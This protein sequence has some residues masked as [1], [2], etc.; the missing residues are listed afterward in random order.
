MP[1]TMRSYRDTRD[2]LAIVA[3]VQTQ[4]LKSRHVIDFPWRLSSPALYTGKDAQLWEDENGVLLG[5]AAWQLSWAALDFFIRPGS[6]SQETENAIF[7]W[8]AQ[9]FCQ[10]DQERGRPLP[11]WVEHRDDDTQRKAISER[12][13]FLLDDDYSYVHMQCSLTEPLPEPVLPPGF[14]IRPLQGQQEV[15]AYVAL[16]RA[17]FEST[18]MTPAWRQRTLFMPQYISE[19]DIVVVAPDGT[20]AGFCVGW[21]NVQRK[22]AQIEPIGV[23]PHYQRHGLGNALL[24]EILRRFQAH[25]AH[26]TIVETESTR[27][28]AQRAYQ[29]VGFRI[30]NTIVRKG[31]LVA[32]HPQGDAPT[33]IREGLSEADVSL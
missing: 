7:T 22:V 2:L 31:L 32:G 33:M 16:H 15:A 18:S 12:H 21:L 9:R 10:L 11:Y 25:G 3:L 30:V 17:A 29:A 24:R 20:L 5:F 4:P 13:G 23:H 27:L 8:A 6:H 28:P 1:I 19:L 26:T 14:T